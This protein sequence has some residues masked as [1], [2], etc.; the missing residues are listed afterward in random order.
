[1]TLVTKKILYCLNNGSLLGWI[2]DPKEKLIFTYILNSHPQ[3]FEEK[4]DLIPVPNFISNWQIS[5]GE[6]FAWLQLK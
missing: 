3:F 4:S 5:L 1:M 2:I 6:I